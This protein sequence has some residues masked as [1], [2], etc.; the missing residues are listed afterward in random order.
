MAFERRTSAEGVV[1]LRSALLA[2][3]GIPH[4][5]ST[6]IG[7]ESPAPFDSLNLGLADAP[8]EPDAWERVERNWKR[9]LRAVGLADRT[10]V[11]LKQVH[12]VLV[13]EAD[14]EPE[15]VRAS[16]PFIEGDALITADRSQAISVR[17]ADCGPLLLADPALGL[18]AAV[19]AGWRGVCGGIVARAMAQM[20]A[21]G[22]SAERMVAAIG[23][24]IGP[25]AFEVGDDVRVAWEGVGLGPFITPGPQGVRWR[26][27][28]VGAIRSQLRSA[29]VP[30]A[31]IDADSTCTHESPELFSYRR[32]GARSGRM[33]ALI[34]L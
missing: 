27:D 17:I 7:G 11:R 8:G 18:V 2:S 25:R 34:G 19:H 6:R 26:A 29:G 3:H 33:A 13:R 14:I 16:P 1:W 20:Q 24:C 4:G 30:T 12:G 15:V 22:A 10:L 5:F 28:L 21:R 23:A 31:S 9:L 32:D